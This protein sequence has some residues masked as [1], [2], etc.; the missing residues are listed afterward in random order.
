MQCW[1][2]TARGP[3]GCLYVDLRGASADAAPSEPHDVLLGF[4]RALGARTAPATVDEASALFRS[5]TA[6][7][8]MLVVLDNAGSAAQ[9]RPLLPSGPRSTT[10]VTSRWRLPDLD[11]TRRLAVEPLPAVAG[12]ELLAHLCGPERVTAEAGAAGDI[13]RLCGGSPLAL[14]IVGARAAG[15]QAPGT[16]GALAA[17]AR[18]LDELEV[19]DLSV[20]AG[21]RVG[22]RSLGAD[23]AATVFRLAAVPEWIEL[24]AAACAAML[25]A[26]PVAVERALDLLLDAHLAARTLFPHDPLPYG[27]LGGTAQRLIGPDATTA[28]AWRWLEQ[29]RVNL[30]MLAGH[31]FAAA[32]PRRSPADMRAGRPPNHFAVR[33][34]G[35]QGSRTRPLLLCRKR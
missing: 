32:P 2:P 8:A 13:V 3:G 28:Q 12:R 19:L 30:R 23:L 29:E 22:Y 31:E 25:D 18:H 15:R 26:P 21:L 16:L 24:G 5:T 33:R 20:R 9:V 11:V 34:V 6:D 10:L 27:D 7:R 17:H 35:H 14:R 1:P 4:L